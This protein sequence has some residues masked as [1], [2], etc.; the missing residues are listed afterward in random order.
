MQVFNLGLLD[1]CYFSFGDA[2]AKPLHHGESPAEDDV[3]P[4][5]RC[6]WILNGFNVSCRRGWDKAAAQTSNRKGARHAVP[7]IYVSSNRTLVPV[8][9]SST[10]PNTSLK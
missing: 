4:K 7:L 9:Q 1:G 2:G 5:L 8:F 3:Q 6:R 10:V